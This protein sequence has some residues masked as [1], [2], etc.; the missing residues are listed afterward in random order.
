LLFHLQERSVS[1]ACRWS[2]VNLWLVEHLKL[3][4]NRPAAPTRCACPHWSG[5]PDG[6][7]WMTG[8]ACGHANVSPGG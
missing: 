1:S 3:D 6:C 2:G 7:W 5:E 8:L 4:E